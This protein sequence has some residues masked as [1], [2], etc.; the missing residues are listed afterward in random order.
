[1]GSNKKSSPIHR[2]N[3]QKIVGYYYYSLKNWCFAS[4]LVTDVVLKIYL[5]TFKM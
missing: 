4:K 1:M 2:M 3:N 5:K